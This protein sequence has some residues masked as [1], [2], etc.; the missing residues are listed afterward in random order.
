MNSDGRPDEQISVS[1]LKF[2]KLDKWAG[3]VKPQQRFKIGEMNCMI[4]PLIE[5]YTEKRDGFGYKSGSWRRYEAWVKYLSNTELEIR[6]TGVDEQKIREIANKLVVN[7]S[8]KN[9]MNNDRLVVKCVKNA[10]K[11]FLFYNT[12]FEHVDHYFNSKTPIEIT[13]NEIE[14]MYTELNRNG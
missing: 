9:I 1:V 6:Q 4:K 8:I 12:K 5:W 2:A 10:R 14:T 13:Q 7:V 3:D 11:D